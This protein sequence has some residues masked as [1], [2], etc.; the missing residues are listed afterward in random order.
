MDQAV[1][2]VTDRLVVDLH[3]DGTAS[4]LTWSADGALPQTGPSFDLVWPLSAAEAEDLRWYLE[5][6]LILPSGVYGE[7]GQRIEGKLPEWG[8]ALFNAVFGAGPARDAYVSLRASQP[9]LVFRTA[10]PALQALPWELLRDP[11]RP[12][13]LA[14]E[15]AGISRG[16]P[17]PPGIQ[18][19]PVR[20]GRL[21]VLM[22]I[23]RPSG[24][25]DVG[26]QMIAR[27]LLERL[28]AV[29]GDVDLAVLRPPTLDALAAALDEAADRG[30]PF[31]LVHF[32]GHGRGS[33]H[34]ASASPSDT[35]YGTRRDEG[36]LVFE[37]P[38]GGPH[39]VPASVVARL[40]NDAKVPVVVL[41][42]C[43]SGA[44]G[45]DTDSAI[46]ARLLSEGTASVV[47]MAYS[48]YAVA[49]AEFMAAFY[50]RLFA[51]DP[52]SAAVTAGR[53]RMDRN[54][55]RPSRKGDMPLA[56]WLVPV[57]YL[58]RDVRFPQAAIPRTSSLSLDAELDQLRSGKR[59]SHETDDLDPVDRFFGRDW[60]ICQLETA[61]RLQKIVLLQGTAGSGKTELAKAFARWWRDTNGVE[62]PGYIFLHSYQPGMATSGLDQVVNDIGR[63][64]YGI[65]F[66]KLGH[67]ERQAMVEKAL[68]KHKMLL[69]WDNFETV[70][71]MPDVAPLPES[72]CNQI[73]DFLAR[74]RSGQSAI[75]ITSRAPESWL[76]DIR[77][78]L[79]EGLTTP[80]ANQY[81]D[82][83]LGPYLTAQ[84]RRSKPSFGDLMEW[85]D[86]HPLSMRLI[87][88]HV[89]TTDPAALLGALRGITD[90]SWPGGGSDEQR[91]SLPAS[92]AYSY[93][94]LSEPTRHIL[95]ALSLL[96]RVADAAILEAFSRV[97]FSPRRFRGVSREA[98]HN[99]LNEAASVGLLGEF[100]TYFYRL[101]PA[102]PGYLA[103]QW[104]HEEPSRYDTDRD[105]ASRALTCALAGFSD[106]LWSQAHSGGAGT[107]FAGIELH[108]HNLAMA[109]RYALAHEMWVEAQQIF[110]V[111]DDHLSSQGLGVDADGWADQVQVAIEK[112]SAQ[113]LDVE[114]PIARL[115][116]TA[117]GGRANRLFMRGEVDRALEIYNEILAWIEPLPRSPEQ[118]TVLILTY[119]H[120]GEVALRQGRLSAAAAW[121][122]KAV[123]IADEIGSKEYLATAY[124]E[125]GTI[126]SE[127]RQF[128]DAERWYRKA[129]TIAADIGDQRAMAGT[130]HQL[131]S[132][133][134]SKGGT[135]DEAEGLYRKSLKILEDIGAK[136]D[137]PTSLQGLAKV[138]LMRGKLDEAETLFGESLAIAEE[139][140]Y[141]PQTASAYRGLGVIAHL[142]DRPDEAEE[143]YA[144]SITIQQE[145]GD[146]PGLSDTFFALSTLS[147][148]RGQT[149]QA[150]AWAIQS[151]SARDDVPHHLAESASS[152]LARL[153]RQIGIDV[154]AQMW[155]EVTGTLLPQA[156]RDYV[157]ES[158]I[159]GG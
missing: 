5:D 57:H 32:D 98:W 114:S 27:P 2:K 151:V 121:I 70:R 65:D 91:K 17:E 8:I 141:G 3:A 60:H 36:I 59:G 103:R 154:L 156:I 11:A 123:E 14:L 126:A 43:Q 50:E 152:A 84:A 34:G 46:A 72:R 133:T 47:A 136:S 135:I 7:R 24:E 131:G 23:S 109:L 113:R 138:V 95:P 155:E 148:A 117:V 66:D 127:Q 22:I 26:Y 25:R 37:K 51:G 150:L 137:M 125:L 6:Y 10:S 16:L 49:A 19:V 1:I 33:D 64:L 45:K 94:H 63:S 9:M 86:G 134:E 73:R 128:D 159:D 31:H 58:R 77:R 142:R 102:L 149:R 110:R 88:P 122:G 35:V 140:G 80:E 52:V 97:P 108:G 78:I 53:R 81:A 39:N 83:L 147:E 92:I 93:A 61:A 144:R 40:L 71:S 20:E 21:R 74:M 120:I 104:R 107:A 153:S 157:E 132:I 129:L 79:V 68:T 44:I 112:T 116:R 42:A 105:A 96:Q 48:V 106:W 82:Y 87:L 130:Y 118:Q 15:L 56:D 29:R 139:L 75:L 111:F 69:I 18:S 99:A 28:G 4:V 76:G 143:W 145:L 119:H 146:K 30:E 41:N 62:K 12:A 90:L 89:E 158:K 115:W 54:S 67:A 124:R 13:P 55:A 85:L 101:H 100:H 38:E